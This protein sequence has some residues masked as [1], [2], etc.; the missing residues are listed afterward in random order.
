LRYFDPD[1]CGEGGF[2]LLISAA[3]LSFAGKN[4][5]DNML[6]RTIPAVLPVTS[7]TNPRRVVLLLFF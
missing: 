2:D 3:L 7:F 1:P 6:A 4:A 5:A